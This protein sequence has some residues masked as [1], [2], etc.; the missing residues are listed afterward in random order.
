MLGSIGVSIW[1]MALAPS[2]TDLVNNE[3]R[4]DHMGN[5]FLNNNK[6]NDGDEHESGDSEEESDSFN[7]LK[8]LEDPRV[9]IGCDDGSVRI[10]AISET[11]EFVCTK[12]LPR[13]DGEISS[14]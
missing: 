7:S 4:H 5:G 3:A 1:Q 8:T 9:A 6:D 11:D 2:K 14:P 12:L 13:V 10:Y